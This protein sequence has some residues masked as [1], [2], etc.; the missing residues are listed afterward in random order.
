MCLWFARPPG[1][2]CKGQVPLQFVEKSEAEPKSGLGN[3]Q[4]VS[5]NT[6]PR[7]D[8]KYRSRSRL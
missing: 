7:Q 6:E 4:W 2:D 1:R 5:G 8:M 3:L